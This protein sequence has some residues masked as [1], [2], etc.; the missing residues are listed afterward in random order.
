MGLAGSFRNIRQHV[1]DAILASCDSQGK[2]KLLIHREYAPFGKVSDQVEALNAR[3][4]DP[5]LALFI[6]TGWF[7][8]TDA[9]GMNR[10]V[11]I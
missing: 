6:Q 8:V 1:I 7:E 9:G 5:A 2:I 11:C 3:Y 10:C 4:Y